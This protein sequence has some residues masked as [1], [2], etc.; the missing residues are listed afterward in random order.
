[1]HD[2]LTQAL[3]EGR[4]AAAFEEMLDRYQDKVFH[5]AVA[6]LGNEAAAQDLT[7]D[8]FVKV[9]KALPQVRA[10]SSLSSWIYTITRNTCL[11]EIKKRAYRRTLSLATEEVALT[12]VRTISPL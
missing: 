9:W 10:E 4:L 2:A 11:T 6:M 8:V 3:A 1:M 12:L 7:Q 5:L